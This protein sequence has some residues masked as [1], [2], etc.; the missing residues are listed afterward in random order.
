MDSIKSAPLRIYDIRSKY[1]VIDKVGRGTY[2]TVFKVLSLEDN[3]FYAIK[4]FENT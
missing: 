2:G 4:K 3:K 1:K